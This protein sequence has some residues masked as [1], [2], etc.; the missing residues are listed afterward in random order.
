MR[1]KRQPS[2]R[3]RNKRLAR[4]S[5]RV[6][7]VRI[8][9]NF[10]AKGRAKLG[11]DAAVLGSLAKVITLPSETKPIRFPTAQLDTN[12]TAVWHLMST[13][14]LNY[15]STSY[16]NQPLMLS[17]SPICPVWGSYNKNT[18]N[19]Y[20]KWS[21]VDATSATGDLANSVF[22]SEFKDS[23]SVKCYPIQTADN[24]CWV[25]F[26]EGALIR[27]T[28][29]GLSGSGTCAVIYEYMEKIGDTTVGRSPITV[30]SGG[31]TG[32]DITSTGLWLTVRSIELTTCTWTQ[33]GTIA[34]ALPAATY[35]GFW[36]VMN[37]P[38][39]SDL[40]GPLQNMRVN[41]ASL[42]AHNASA[43]LY[44]NGS[45]SAGKL[46]WDSVNIWSPAAAIAKINEE[47][48]SLRFF[49]NAETGAYT[50][51]V[52]S[53]D[54]LLYS[55][56]IGVS[57]LGY[58]YVQDAGDYKDVNY[59]SFNVESST[60]PFLL[61][62]RY[63]VHLESITNSQLYH[64]GV[65]MIPYDEFAAVVAAAATLV[66]F[67]ENPLH[68]VLAALGVKVLK[69]LTPYLLPKAHNVIDSLGARIMA[70]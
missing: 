68:T 53:K 57:D 7:R 45:V 44:R 26:P 17:H 41:A 8:A 55:D 13:K 54:S 58:P 3:Q 70:L 10:T 14:Q 6:G 64:L 33:S 12:K 32:T 1:P 20:G 11:S 49:E 35:Q 34:F 30:T 36:P 15:G 48:E 51:L 56:Y 24:A 28:V 60:S 50:Y 4:D 59:M 5:K 23:D 18:S 19:Y 65:P 47:N 29:T 40:T 69:H 22:L 38:A 43:P 42:L 61:A 46:L 66:P 27:P 62:L 16:P 2:Q 25:Y 39:L 37:G 31:G 9:R 52:P 21:L 67:T 63:D